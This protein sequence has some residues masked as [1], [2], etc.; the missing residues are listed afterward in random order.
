MNSESA[1]VETLKEWF[2]TKLPKNEMIHIANE[3]RLLNYTKEK[4]ND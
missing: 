2:L 4:S 1:E 3:F